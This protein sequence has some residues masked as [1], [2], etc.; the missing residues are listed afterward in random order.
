LATGERAK[1]AAAARRAESGQIAVG[2]VGS[3]GMGC[4]HA[5]NLRWKVP[6]A[7]LAAVADPDTVRAEEL[8]GRCG[9][10]A[11]FEDP[12]DLI[13][14][15]GI[16]A[17]VVASPDPTHAPLVLECL[18]NEKPVLCEK[19]LADS[20][21]AGLQVVEAEIDLGKRLVQVGF[22]RRYDP[23][24]VAVKEAV[25]SGTVGAP[26]L[27]KGWHR[28][29][30]F[31]QGRGSESVV[32][33]ATIHDL[34]STRWFLGQEIA[35]V[36]ARGVN[37]EPELG[38]DVWDLQLIQLLTTGGRM[39]TIETYVTARYGYEVGVEIVGERGTVQTSP[40][41]G[42]VVRREGMV[43]QRIEQDWLERFRAAYEVEA[44]LW[45]ESLLDGTP[46]GPDAWDGYA[47]LVAADACVASLRSGSPER[48]ARLERP[49]FYGGQVPGAGR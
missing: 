18:R 27:F 36:Y 4:M 19:P 42:A 41:A 45:V 29:V 40:P 5:E 48:V 25:E 43:S 32:V 6:G 28:N 17:V 16:E 47:S 3:G 39:G 38:E 37:T 30:G 8:A 44:R 9:P 46:G 33:S 2:V 14:D 22:M 1:E 31:G 12:V 13:R 24:H 7:R 34:D 23:Q 11:V 20:S 21:S 35:E 10:A 15:P 26:M 49:A